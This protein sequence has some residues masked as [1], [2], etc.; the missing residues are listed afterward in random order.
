MLS[1]YTQVQIDITLYFLAVATLGYMSIGLCCPRREPLLFPIPPPQPNQQQVVEILWALAGWYTLQSG[2]C[3][4]LFR[5]PRTNQ[6]IYVHKGSLVYPTEA[7]VRRRGK[8]CMVNDE[9]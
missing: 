5:S 3:V 1:V 2:E 7:A 8:L 4:P 6:W 9:H